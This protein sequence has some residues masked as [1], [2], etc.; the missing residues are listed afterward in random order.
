MPPPLSPTGFGI[1]VKKSIFSAC[2]PCLI[3]KK[4]MNDSGTSATS[5]DSPQNATKHED[6][7]LRQAV[8]VIMPPPPEPEA[9]A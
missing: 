8:R 4:R 3:T 9:P 2:T 6:R 5:T 7:T 1:C